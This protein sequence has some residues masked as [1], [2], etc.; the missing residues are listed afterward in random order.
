MCL[1]PTQVN[2][3]SRMEST[4]EANKIQLS[5][6]AAA[7]MAGDPEL[8][9]LIR[10][11]P[12]ETEVKGQGTMCTSWLQ[13]AWEAAVRTD[14]R[15][16]VLQMARKGK[17]SGDRLNGLLGERGSGDHTNIDLPGPADAFDVRRGSF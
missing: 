8:G 6:T 12:G 2:I 15:S 17:W 14:R 11:R 3:A 1:L 9:P 7:T 16:K 4:G 5:P 13:T 10:R